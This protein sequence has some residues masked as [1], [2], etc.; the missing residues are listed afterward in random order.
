MNPSNTPPTVVTNKHGNPHQNNRAAML[1]LVVGCIVF[2][3]GSIIVATVAVGGYA[4]AFWRLLVAGIIFFIL[5]KLSNQAL[6][7]A[8]KARWLAILSGVLLAFDL[9]F[10]H[11]SIYAVGPGISTLLNSLQIFFLAFIGFVWFG[12]KQSKLQLSSL[13]LAIVGVAMIAGREFHQNQQAM[14]GFVMGIASGAMLAGSMSLIRVAHNLEQRQTGRQIDIFALMLL[15]SM[16]GVVALI[17]PMLVFDSGALY[18]TTW[19]EVGLILVYGAVM[20]CFAWGLIA[21]SIPKLTLAL[22]GLLLLCEPIAALLIDY[23]FLLKPINALQWLGAGITMVAIYLG[24]LK[25]E[26]KD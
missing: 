14:L 16:G 19:Q 20:Q 24:S 23:F 11:E 5:L 9:A 1:G 21:Y 2:G 6:P 26:T 13:I 25:S 22:T 12:E 10:W 15:L 8:L 7:S 3:L 17:L 4:I 18:P